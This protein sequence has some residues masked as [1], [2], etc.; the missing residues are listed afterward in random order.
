MP[1]WDALAADSTLY[2]WLRTKSSKFDAGSSEG[3]VTKGERKR[4]RAE[5]HR[6]SESA[7]EGQSKS[8]REG[9]RGSR[10]EKERDTG[11]RIRLGYKIGRNRGVYI[12]ICSYELDPADS[13]MPLDLHL[14]D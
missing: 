14:R 5:G 3:R 9:H 12:L 4:H 11:K 1:E 2:S 10:R 6:E 13:M 7:R 8:A